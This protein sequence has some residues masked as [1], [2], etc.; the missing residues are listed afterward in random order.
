[1]IAS[2]TIAIGLALA[3]PALAAAADAPGDRIMPVPATYEASAVTVEEH[4]GARLPIDAP[5]RDTSGRRVTLGEVIAAEPLPVILTFNYSD[6]PLLCSMQLN[7][8]TA[9]MPE[10]AAPRQGEL[11]LRA[12]VHY[13][14]VTISLDPHESPEK[15]VRMRERYLERLPEAHRE[16]ARRGWT[17]LA[18]PA[19]GEAVSVRRVAEV[20]GFK[21]AYVAARAEWAHPSSFIFISSGGAV[22][23][24]V[25][26]FEIAADVLRESIVRAGMAEP[27][28]SAGFFHLCYF[29]DPDA[30]DHSRAGVTALRIGAAGFVV[31]LLAGLGVLHLTRRA[32]EQP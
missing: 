29:Y 22:T 32:R 2:R 13:R 31:L 8:L 1:M 14:I 23:R 21:Y 20:V 18:A 7:G 25:H 26:G 5:F 6:C 17:L 11:A 3:A 10:V 24:Y 12:G 9:A 16:A 19:P 28:A 27:S 4:L 30:N 15:L